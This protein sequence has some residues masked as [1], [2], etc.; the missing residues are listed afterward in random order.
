[1]ADCAMG[2]TAVIPVGTRM[3]W[4]CRSLKGC[5]TESLGE[6]EKMGT[7]VSFPSGGWEIEILVI[8]SVRSVLI[9]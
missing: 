9:V 4:R 5:G 7:G 3:Y 8:L 2:G 6:V 1:M